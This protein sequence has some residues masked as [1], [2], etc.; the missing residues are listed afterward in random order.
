MGRIKGT[1]NARVVE[2]YFI[3]YPNVSI[4]VGEI[5]QATSL[6][7]DQVRGAISYLRKQASLGKAIKIDTITTG[8][9]WTYTPV[10]HTA[11]K[12]TAAATQKKAKTLIQEMPN[13]VEGQSVPVNT[14][15]TEEARKIEA[16][17]HPDSPD[18]KSNGV[19]TLRGEMIFAELGRDMNGVLLVQDL[20][21]QVYRVVPV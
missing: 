16:E 15:P 13:K 7:G 2:K 6:S 10:L 14:S 20:N 4:D 17:G 9:M 3:D 21:G 11:K 12:A 19:N 1:N 8:Y 18:S 5:T